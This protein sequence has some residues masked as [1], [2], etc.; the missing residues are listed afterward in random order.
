MTDEQRNALR[1]AVEPLMPLPK[2]FGLDF[3]ERLFEL[4]P[5][6]ESQFRPDLERQAALFAEALTSGIVHLIDEGQI[7][8]GVRRYGVQLR[9]IGMIESDYDAFG[10]AL[11]SMFERKLGDELTAEA[12]AAWLET[13]DLLSTEM[14]KAA[15][16]ATAEAAAAAENAEPARE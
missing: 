5:G 16:A 11:T 15:I 6:L 7:A 4:E 2:K 1:L 3:F 8:E 13:W 14:L 10:K 12:R 9:G